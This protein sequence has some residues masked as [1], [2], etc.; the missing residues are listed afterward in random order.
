MIAQKRDKDS[1]GPTSKHPFAFKRWYKCSKERE[2]GTLSKT[3]CMLLPSSSP[4]NLPTTATYPAACTPFECWKRRV[5][6]RN[7]K[8]AEAMEGEGV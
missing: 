3:G 2:R 4:E 1:L 6:N 7:I 8:V 5:T